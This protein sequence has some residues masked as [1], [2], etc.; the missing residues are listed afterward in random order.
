MSYTHKP[1]QGS[2]FK[3]DRK[4]KD[5]HPDFTGTIMVGEKEMRLSAWK[6][7][8]KN[9]EFYSLSLTE[10]KPKSNDNSIPF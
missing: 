7:Q 9:G 10:P 6:K 3:N 4:E 5:T 2:L 8:G 1:N